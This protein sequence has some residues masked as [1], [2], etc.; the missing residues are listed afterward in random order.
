MN[1]FLR[2]ALRP[3]EAFPLRTE[4][5]P[6][7]LA[8]MLAWRVPLAFLEA[9]LA[10]RALGAFRAEAVS[11]Q[12]PLWSEVVRRLPEEVSPADLRGWL[13]Q[14][15]APA[16]LAAAWPWLLLAAAVGVLGA[17]AHHAVW[18]HGCLWLL[19]G[20]KKEGPGFRASLGAEAQALEVGAL[21]AALGLLQ[22]LPRLGPWLGLPLGAVGLWFWVLRGFALARAQGAPAWKGAVATVL[23]AL[24]AGC[25]LTLL[26][27]MLMLQL[28]G[29]LGAGA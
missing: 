13:E 3:W 26:L 16:P 4:S 23:H 10:W 11:L 2:A 6:R 28:L 12:G 20:V 25:C 15:P 7:A 18:D 17:W 24:L 19:G 9:L 29:A 14:I 27:L 1:P 21:G 22:Y 5:W 8:R